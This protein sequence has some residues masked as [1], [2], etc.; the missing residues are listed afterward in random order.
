MDTDQLTPKAY[1]I[2]SIAYSEHTWLHSEIGAD[3]IQYE[4]EEDFLS[5]T[6]EYVEELLEDPSDYLDDCNLLEVVNITEFTKKLVKLKDHIIETKK[7]PI[8]GRGKVQ[9]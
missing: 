4:N 3:A 2:I 7:T 9:L 1:E 5:G 8:E 6:L